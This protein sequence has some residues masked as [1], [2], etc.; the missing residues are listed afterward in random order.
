MIFPF[1][2]WSHVTCL[3]LNCTTIMTRPH[4]DSFSTLTRYLTYSLYDSFLALTHLSSIYTSVLTFVNTSLALT[5]I[6]LLLIQMT[7]NHLR[8]TS[9]AAR[10]LI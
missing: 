5:E 1:F 4:Y 6:N 9:I 3:F 10:I 7:P 8:Q 2:T